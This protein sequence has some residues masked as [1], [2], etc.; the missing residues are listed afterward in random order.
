MTNNGEQGALDIFGQWGSGKTLRQ[1]AKESGTSSSVRLMGM[2]ASVADEMEAVMEEAVGGGFLT[3]TP[4]MRV[5]RRYI[6]EICDGLVPALQRR[7]LVRSECTRTTLR[8]H[9]LEF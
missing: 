1:L 2:P 3:I 4:L 9:L 8:G 6:G 5:S 7:G